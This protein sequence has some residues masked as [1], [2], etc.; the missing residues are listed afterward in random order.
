MSVKSM[1]E[2]HK[3]PQYGS[4][5]FYAGRKFYTGRAKSSTYGVSLLVLGMARTDM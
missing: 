5:T 2:R 4:G 1:S 3:C